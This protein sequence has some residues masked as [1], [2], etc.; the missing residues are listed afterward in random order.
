MKIFHSISNITRLREVVDGQR[1]F[2]NTGTQQ[3]AATSGTY[4]QKMVALLSNISQPLEGPVKVTQMLKGV[5]S[6][7]KIIDLIYGVTVTANLASII[8]N[9]FSE[10]MTIG[11]SN[12]AYGAPGTCD[13]G[14]TT[15][16]GNG[17]VWGERNQAVKTMVY[18]LENV[19]NTQNLIGV[20]NGTTPTQ[21]SDLINHVSS[22]GD[23]TTNTAFLG[24]NVVNREDAGVGGGAANTFTLSGAG[25]RL[26]KVIDYSSNAAYP[27]DLAFLMN[28]TSTIKVAKLIIQMPIGQTVAGAIGS[29]Q[30]GTGKIGNLLNQ[31]SG[32]NCFNLD[33]GVT[34]VTVGGGGGAGYTAAPIVSFAGGGG[35]GATAVATVSGGVV[36]NIYVTNPGTTSYGGGA[37][38]VTLTPVSGGAGATGTAVRGSCGTTRGLQQTGPN[39]ISNI[40]KGKLVNMLNYITAAN[41]TSAMNE[42]RNLINNVNTPAANPGRKLG[43]LVNRVQKSSNLVALVNAVLDANNNNGG[44]TTNLVALMNQVPV[45]GIQKLISL[46]NQ[47]GDAIETTTDTLAGPDQNLVAQL[48]A[49]NAA[50]NTDSGAGGATFTAASTTVT[51]NGHG[52]SVNDSVVFTT[53]GTLPAAIT[54]GQAYFVTSVTPPNQFTIG[55]TQGATS[56][57]TFA[58]AGVG[59]HRAWSYG[60]TQTAGVGSSTMVQLLGS[61]DVFYCPGCF[62][63]VTPTSTY[64]NGKDLTAASFGVGALNGGSGTGAAATPVI[65]SGEVTRVNLLTSGQCDTATLP[66]ISLSGGGFT[67]AATISPVW[68]PTDG[69]TTR[70]SLVGVIVTDGGAGYTSAPTVNVAGCTGTAPTFRPGNNTEINGL[71]AID[72]TN[73]GTG[74]ATN[75][76]P[77]L[78][79]TGTAPAA[80]AMSAIAAGG[81]NALSFTSFNPSATGYTNGHNCP[82]LG[83][84]GSGAVVQVSVTGGAVTGISSIISAGSDYRSGQIVT[85]GGTARGYAIVSAGGAIAAGAG[86]I[87]ANFAGCGYTAAPTVT[88]E[89]CA[90]NPTATAALN[91]NGGVGTITVTVA[92][93]GCPRNPRVI[94]GASPASNATAI[95]GGVVSGYLADVSLTPGANNMAGVLVNA[96]KV[97]LYSATNY[98]SNIPTIS[99]REAMVRLLYTG[100]AYTSGLTTFG[101]APGLGPVHLGEV[102]NLVATG[103][104]TQ[105]T[106]INLLNNPTTGLQDIAPL[107]GCGDRVLFAWDNVTAPGLYANDWESFCNATM[108]SW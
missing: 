94:I 103:G 39:P 11:C 51:W 96:N 31:I 36:T 7:D 85:I 83:A 50:V 30:L 40:G 25:M 18:V 22:S 92:G 47:M 8:N 17:F 63:T 23:S 66:T 90:V 91:G 34:S 68:V 21:V 45:T 104:S 70:S 93:S 102:M 3:T 38:A 24:L 16:A 14:A 29:Y 48:M 60:P 97:P 26:V 57:I 13:Q 62:P 12:T 27:Y 67:T 52:L 108:G 2:D 49:S 69:S 1:V 41:D 99:A 87:I 55:T 65:G 100:V 15:T 58:T 42:M 32:T 75:F 44:A 61:L 72:V 86:S 35:T 89:G 53:A 4:L 59:A 84:G 46:V 6:T 107:L 95:L 106:I 78:T 105:M 64:V 73:P 77:T 28:K 19:V 9:I 56:S 10:S 54:A 81:L 76:T 88:V 82:V 71:V 74:Y 5:T 101:K 80:N 20:I 37:P 43:D 33:N 98:L 79:V